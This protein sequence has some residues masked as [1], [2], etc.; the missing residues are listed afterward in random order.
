MLPLQGDFVI[1]IKSIYFPFGFAEVFNF[2]FRTHAFLQSSLLAT[3]SMLLEKK[4]SA[5]EFNDKG[6]EEGALEK[7][8]FS[9]C[10]L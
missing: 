6:V 5:F 8:F 4:L 9:R 2:L 7:E 3:M 1:Y 10:V